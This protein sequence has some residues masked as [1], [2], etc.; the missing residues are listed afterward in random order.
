MCVYVCVCVCVCDWVVAPSTGNKQFGLSRTRT[1]PGIYLGLL[2]SAE[3]FSDSGEGTGI[4]LYHTA[5][6][7][8]N[9]TFS[10]SI[11]RPK[12]VQGCSAAPEAF[13][14]TLFLALYLF[15]VLIVFAIN[16]M[17]ILMVTSCVAAIRTGCSAPHAHP[18]L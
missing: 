11:N 3:L 4:N 9:C 15:E 18:H 12:D 17:R 14:F 1:P 6:T 2:I 10:S 7:V 8:Q 16:A 13:S 5:P